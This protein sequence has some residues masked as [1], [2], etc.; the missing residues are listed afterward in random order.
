MEFSGHK[1]HE[2]IKAYNNSNEDQKIQNT[3][4]LIPFDY[5][6]LPYEEFNYF[7][8]VN[9]LDFENNPEIYD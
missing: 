5:N 9:L 1:S 8:S 6:N 3:A 7:L 2:G 4:L